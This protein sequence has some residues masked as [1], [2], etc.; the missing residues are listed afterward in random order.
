MFPG[1]SVAGAAQQLVR[2]HNH[3]ANE[4]TLLPPHRA[5]EFLMDKGDGFVL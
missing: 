4:R 1:M 5:P 2:F 3:Y